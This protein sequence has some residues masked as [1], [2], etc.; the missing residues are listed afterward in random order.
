M[1]ERICTANFVQ[2]SPIIN[3]VHFSRSAMSNN[4][5]NL[6]EKK[7]K[8]DEENDFRL[9][10]FRRRIN[11]SFD[12]KDFVRSKIKRR[13]SSSLSS[14]ERICNGYFNVCS[15]KIF[16]SFL[17][18]RASG[19][20]DDST[21]RNENLRFVRF[22]DEFYH[23]STR[24]EL[25]IVNVVEHWYSIHQ[26]WDVTTLLMTVHP[27]TPLTHVH[28]DEKHSISIVSNEIYEWKIH[29]NMF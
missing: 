27:K 11:S 28:H 20:N 19:Y 4:N 10:N 16:T 18:S 25:R 7:R 1:S 22:I 12:V 2:L 9:T 6:Q 3:L 13:K 26:Q 29:R 8:R 14:I 21:K 23:R 5:F 24:H 15:T 17:M